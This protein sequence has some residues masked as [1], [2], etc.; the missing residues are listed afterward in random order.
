[1]SSWAVKGVA[2][3]MVTVVAG[4]Q[5]ASSR[6]GRGVQTGLTGFKVSSWL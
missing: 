6:V 3:G 5:C 4:V 1:M 2:V